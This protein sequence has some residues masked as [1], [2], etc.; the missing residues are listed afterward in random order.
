MRIKGAMCHDAL[1]LMEKKKILIM[2]EKRSKA[3]DYPLL[4]WNNASAV[5]WL[6]NQAVL[7]AAATF[8]PGAE[9]PKKYYCQQKT[10]A[11]AS[12]TRLSSGSPDDSTTY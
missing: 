7:I 10:R 1:I 6:K 3:D 2:W 9:A 11:L 8:I 4:F 5:C 12:L